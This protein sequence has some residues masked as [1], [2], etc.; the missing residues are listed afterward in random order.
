MYLIAFFY[1]VFYVSEP[2]IMSEKEKL[3]TSDKGLLADFFDKE[4]VLE[5]FRVAFK[6]GENNRRMKVIMLMVSLT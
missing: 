5:T 1:G 4:H 6:E 3:K 2:S